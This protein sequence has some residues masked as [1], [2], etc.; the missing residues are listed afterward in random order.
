MVE[1]TLVEGNKLFAGVCSD[2]CVCER[3]DRCTT[4]FADATFPGPFERVTGT[5][6][7]EVRQLPGNGDVKDA[8]HMCSDLF[9]TES[10]C[11]VQKHHD[12]C[13]HGLINFGWLSMV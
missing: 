2:K 11:G 9:A 4:R 5:V 10:C 12:A 1:P 7:Q 13:E 6:N 3:L 8:L